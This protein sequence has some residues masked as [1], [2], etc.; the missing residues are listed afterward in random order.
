MVRI[1][2][3]S[4]IIRFAL[5]NGIKVYLDGGWGVDALLGRE[6][7]IH[8]DIDLFVEMRN[9][10]D[11]IHIIK[12][13]GFSEVT[14]EYTT[15]NH[16]VWNDDKQRIID[17]HCFEF[18]NDGILYEGDIFPLETFSGTG[19][20]GDITVSCIEP[21]SQVMFHLGYEHDENDVHDV[22]LLCEAFQIAIPGEYK[23]K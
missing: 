18:I 10:H 20:V 6:T 9:Y 16:T 4:E 8:N 21:F 14:M 1:E 13:N 11:Y 7:R 3:A 22:M 5:Q 23:E 2:D 15:K 19:K 17:L 12:E